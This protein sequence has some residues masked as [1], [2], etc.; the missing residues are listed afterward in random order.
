MNQAL[1]TVTASAAVATAATKTE[2]II[3]TTSLI[4]SQPNDGITPSL[5]TS[6]VYAL[7][8]LGYDFGSEARRDSFKQLM[9]NV[10]LD[11]I[12]VPANPYDARQMASYLEQN[13]SEAKSLIWTL[14]QKLTPIYAIDPKG[15]FAADVYETLQAMLVG[16]V[17]PQESE[18]YI[19][20]VSFPGRL[21]DRTIELFS[22][23][24][25]PVV[26]LPNIRGMYGWK[27]NSLVDAAVESATTQ[28]I[29]ALEIRLRR[30]LSSCLL[31]TS[32]SP[33]DSLASRMPSFA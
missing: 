33:R 15:A 2:T 28:E 18:E 14:N 8:S 19:E 13:F 29:S 31:Y 5:K 22:G 12:A 7:G 21:T 9:P 20:R 6:L 25:V 23:Q 1:A 11:G 32:P 17:Q 4:A 24:V 27:V 30:S 26:T 16:Q 3:P 10:E